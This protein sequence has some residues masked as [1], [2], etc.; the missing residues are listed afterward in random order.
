MTR[1]TYH[2]TVDAP[3]E[4]VWTVVSDHRVYGEVAPNLSSVDLVDGEGVGAVRR[5]VDA[6]C[7][8]WTETITEW[9]PREGYAVEVDVAESEFHRRLFHRFEGEWRLEDVE[10]GV[11]ITIE[12]TF[13]PR[14]GPL[15]RL[16]AG[17]FAYKAPG[18]VEPIFDGWVAAIRAESADG[19]RLTNDAGS[20]CSTDAPPA[21]T[22]ERT[23]PR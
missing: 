8:A 23:A 5:C 7:N 13:E 2:R 19:S 1:L 16:I 18:I 6:D 17:F 10:D 14:Y 15:G 20:T 9:R 4:T 22:A 12:F 21:E 3:I 11:R